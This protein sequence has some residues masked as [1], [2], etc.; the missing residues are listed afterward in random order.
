NIGERLM[1]AIHGRVKVFHSATATYFSPSE[2]AG[3]GGMHRE[4]IRCTPQRRNG[5]ER[6]DTV[7]VSL[8]PAEEGMK[9]MVVGR[10][11][12]FKSVE[13]N[14]DSYPCTL[15]ERFV[16]RHDRPDP[17]TRVWVV[18]P[19]IINGSRVLL[20]SILMQLCMVSI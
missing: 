19:E 8:D 1:P 2:L 10:V 3:A 13:H 15:V 5:Y 12:A 7:L 11:R 18:E 9:G 6:Y 20:L 14:R 17:S 4:W 16:R